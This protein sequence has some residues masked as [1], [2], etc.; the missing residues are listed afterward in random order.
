[1][2]SRHGRGL[3]VGAS[4]SP[5]RPI[6]LV[7]ALL[8]MWLTGMNAAAE[9][10]LAIEVIRNPLVIAPSSVGAP[11]L[12]SVVRGAFVTALA[13]AGRV[14]LPLG[15]AELLLGGTMVFVAAKAL[16]GR[17]AS[18]SF[19]LQVIVANLV[20]LVVGYALRQ[21]VR[22]RVVDAV[23]QSGLEER[24]AQLAAADFDTL[25]RA[26]WWWSFRVHLGLQIA[27]LSL[28]GFA[29]TRRSAREL[30][31]PDEKQPSPEEEG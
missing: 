17:R 7:I 24:P 26:K 2:P 12:D 4:A 29:L 3:G 10:W 21:P 6:Y 14:N 16:F 23:M 18:P 20:V 19:A 15:I 11:D 9:G 8:A 13:D 1:M 30:L 22:G 28:S 27:A 31:S 25:M 5:R